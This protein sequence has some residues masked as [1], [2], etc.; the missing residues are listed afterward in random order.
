MT[1]IVFIGAERVGLACLRQLVRMGKNVVGVFT[2]H[3]DLRPRIA[4]FVSFHEFVEPL[5]I[6]YVR[7][8][9]T[10]SPAFVEQVRELRPDLIV[11]ISWSQIIPGEVLALPPLGCVGIHYSLLPAR[12]GGAPLNWALIDGLCETGI[13]LLYLDE[14]IDTGDIIAQRKFPIARDDTVKTL[15]DKIV[16][17]APQLVADNIELLE[18][19]QAPR[20]KQD[21][22]LASYTRRRRPEDSQINW[23]MSDE[24]LYNFIRALAP[25]YPCAFTFVGRRKLIVPSANIKDGRL[26]IEGYL[27]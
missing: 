22:R 24:E 16:V 20:Q 6:P 5:G 27:E 18:Q 26:W 10:K 11:V 15:L 25:P 17:L 21:E 3:D 7:V 23:S 13:A 8:T 19:G 2:A 4:D 9:S 1:R 14:G 12:R